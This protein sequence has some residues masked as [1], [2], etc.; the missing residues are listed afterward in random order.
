ME[1]SSWV[2]CRGLP[3]ED[4]LE[5]EREVTRGRRFLFE[6]GGQLEEKTSRE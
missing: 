2:R 5:D 6:D 3:L 4:I 1:A